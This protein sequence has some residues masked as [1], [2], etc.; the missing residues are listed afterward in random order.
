[1]QF[2]A[3]HLFVERAKAMQASFRHGEQQ[4]P[5]IV[6]ICQRLDGIPL[7]LELAAA[8]VRALSVE[9]IAARVNDR[10]RLLSSGDRTRRRDSKRCGR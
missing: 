3:V 7:A 6:E 5:A 4:L 1:M 2:E 10:F 9:Q 8:R